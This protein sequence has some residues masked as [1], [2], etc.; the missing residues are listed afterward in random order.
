MRRNRFDFSEIQAGAA[1]WSLGKQRNR[2]HAKRVFRI[3]ELLVSE[4]SSAEL[5]IL[6][7][8]YR[9]ANLIDSDGKP[10]LQQPPDVVLSEESFQ[11]YS[12]V[13]VLLDLVARDGGLSRIRR[14]RHVPCGNWFLALNR[15][16]QKFCN[17][18]G[19]F[20]RQDF[21]AADE[22]V[23]REKLAT[24]KKNYQTKRNNILEE[25]ERLVLPRRSARK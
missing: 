2:P 12:A 6:L 3:V 1:L 16:D 15:D 13:R 8:R 10:Y 18:P 4:K 23:H 17:E 25:R 21:Y 5:T 20:C 11:E 9:W 7:S 22:R 24:M 19:R 14:C